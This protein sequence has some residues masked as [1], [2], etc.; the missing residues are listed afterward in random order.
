[1]KYLKGLIAFGFASLLVI[2]IANVSS[3]NPVESYDERFVFVAPISWNSVASG[4]SAADREFGTNTRLVGSKSLNEERMLA[5]MEAAIASGVDGII[6]A[7]VF[8]TPEMYEMIRKAED[9]GIPVVILDSDLSGAERSTY[10][11]TNNY[12]AGITSGKDLVEVTGGSARIAVVV[13]ELSASNQQERLN[14]LNFVLEQYPDMQVTEVLECHSN[15]HEIAEKLMTALKTHPEIDTLCFLEGRAGSCFGGFLE[16][17]SIYKGKL[18][19]VAFDGSDAT[20]RYV[21]DG[22][23][24]STIVQKQYEEGYKAVETLYQI[25]HGMEPN[26]TVYTDV[27]SIR[28][29]NISS[30]KKPSKEGLVWHYY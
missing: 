25:V 1:M 26:D 24:Y 19:I 6:T 8:G 30:Y 14:G 11:G 9:S 21:Q 12:E 13:S 18:R 16:K 17:D 20:I 29:N 23:Y 10:V 28:K 22:T 3:V 15:Y 27:Q 7:G 5:E 4:I 2:F